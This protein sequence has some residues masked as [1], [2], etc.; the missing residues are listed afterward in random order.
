MAR[1]LDAKKSFEH[2]PQSKL[3]KSKLCLIFFPE[4]GFSEGREKIDA[5]PCVK[6]FFHGSVEAKEG[7]RDTSTASIAGGI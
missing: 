4:N 7:R 3:E 6:R 1:Q 2:F 5:R